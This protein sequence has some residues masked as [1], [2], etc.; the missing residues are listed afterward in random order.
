LEKGASK[1]ILLALISSFK[2]EE[3][4]EGVMIFSETIRISTKGFS[5]IIDIT[6]QVGSVVRD[7]NIEKGRLSLGTWQ[8]IVFI[9]F[10]NRSRDR[11]ILVP[12]MGE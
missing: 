1:D 6:D 12:I 9:D 5:D 7:S 10:D 2:R 11:R 8:Q 3:F 4:K